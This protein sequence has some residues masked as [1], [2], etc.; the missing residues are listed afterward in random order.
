MLI[1]LE[2]IRTMLNSYRYPTSK[3]W[4]KSQIRMNGTMLNPA[5]GSYK[6]SSSSP[7]VT[8]MRWMFRPPLT[9]VQILVRMH[10]CSSLTCLAI[11]DTSVAPASSISLIEDILSN[12]KFI[13]SSLLHVCLCITGMYLLPGQLIKFHPG[14]DIFTTSE[15]FLLVWPHRLVCRELIATNRPSNILFLL[16]NLVGPNRFAACNELKFQAVRKCIGTSG[17]AI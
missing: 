3:T 17:K 10:Q 6:I 9:I 14:L 15:I 2:Y 1:R 13:Q 16:P 8:R 11:C 4:N 7:L 12:G 5:R